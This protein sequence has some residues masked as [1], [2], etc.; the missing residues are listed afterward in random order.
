MK[1]TDH[2]LLPID[3]LWMMLYFVGF[4][5]DILE[6]RWCRHHFALSDFLNSLYDIGISLWIQF[7]NLVWKTINRTVLVF[8]T[9]SPLYFGIFLLAKEYIIL[10][11]YCYYN[12]KLIEPKYLI[13][14][15]WT[16]SRMKNAFHWPDF[17]ISY[18]H[19]GCLWVNTW[20]AVS[21]NASSDGY[22]FLETNQQSCISNMLFK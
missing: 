16:N 6:F 13:A 15:C 1:T 3:L 21:Q 2:Y 20:H 7:R 11:S 4:A 14:Y 10:I 22:L 17:I 18:M 5:A 8:L 19:Y 9:W 12:I